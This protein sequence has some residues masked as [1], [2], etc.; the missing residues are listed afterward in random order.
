M[1]EEITSAYNR[2]EPRTGLSE[3][4]HLGQGSRGERASSEAHSGDHVLLANGKT[5]LRV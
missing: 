1:N 2:L 5:C 4:Q 3:S